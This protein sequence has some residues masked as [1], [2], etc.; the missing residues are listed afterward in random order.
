MITLKEV[1][2]K[3]DL[4]VFVKFPFQLYKNSKYWV[5]PIISD[6][7][8]SFDKNENPVFRN[9]EATLFLAYKNNTIVGRIAAI[10]NWLE[11]NQQNVKKMRF[12]WFDFIDDLEVSKALLNKVEEIGKS[13]NL[14][15]AEGPVGF[16][17]LDKV[18]VMS[19]GFD[20]VATMIGWYNHAYYIKHYEAAGYVVEKTF[21][22][23]QF[24]VSAVEPAMYTKVSKI[25]KTRYGVKSLSFT[26][27]KDV[28]PYVD[29]MFDLFN[30]TYANL[31][32]FV[33]ITDEQK[34]YFKKKF[35]SFIN[36]EYI[37]FVLDKNNELIGFAIVL[38][39]FAKALQKA[40]GKLF[41]FGF[42]HLLQAKKHSKE[43]VFYLIGIHPDYQNKG[44]HALIFEEYHKVFKAKG[45]ETCI[46]TPELKENIAIQ[47]IWKHFNSTLL[48]KRKT[49]K[50]DL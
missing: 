5:P 6:E 31:S 44:V 10:V 4:K 1:K 24:L 43:A 11:V 19:E 45:V 9:A 33:A 32:S 39:G 37:K 12:G 13:H 15:Y 18:G 16:S 47:Q 36:P 34:V 14:E 42:W 46:R 28:M 29:N 25:I 30:T 21:S 49:Y 48:R 41:P 40:K 23:S 17:N 38:P 27:T 3:S 26:K 35:I 2:T 8:K 22:E 20:T 50:K 7:M